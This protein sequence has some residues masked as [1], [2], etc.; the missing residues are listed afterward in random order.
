VPGS[1]LSTD[2]ERKDLQDLMD[3]AHE[4]EIRNIQSEA[5]LNDLLANDEVIKG[6]DPEEVI[7]AYNEVS[8]FAPYA[9]NKKAIMRDLM[10]KRLA[11]GAAALDQF[12]V[13]EAL[14]QQDTMRTMSSPNEDSMRAFQDLGVMPSGA[15]THRSVMGG[16]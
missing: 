7:D 12:T 14:K 15:P 3:P 5:M 4:S 11:G 1:Q 6:Y 16:R 2:L 10:R 13:G 9:S 8:Q